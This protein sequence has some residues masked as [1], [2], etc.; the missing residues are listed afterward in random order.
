MT[1][2]WFKR[3]M[4]RHP[5]LSLRK[6]NATANGRTDCLN[7][8]TMKQHFSL[9]K[10]ALQEHDV[11]DS[12]AQI[13]NDDET[14]M[15]LDLRPPKVVTEKGQKKVRYRTSGNKSQ[16]TVIGCVSAVGNPPVCNFLC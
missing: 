10:D 3:F 7:P 14:G 6:D 16:I 8:D 5:K 11:M 13:Y 4:D 2:G 15:P 1:D 9:L 12:P